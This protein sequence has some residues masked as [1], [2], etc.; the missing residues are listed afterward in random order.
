MSGVGRRSFGVMLP[1]FILYILLTFGLYGNSLA[2]WW[3]CDDPQI[4]KHALAHS[5][6]EYFSNPDVWRALIPYSLTP[7]LS[8]TYDLD[9][10]LFG[11]NPFGYFAHNLLVIAFCACLIHTI[12][13]QWV[14]VWH[15][16][17]GALLFL[18]GSPVMVASQ[19]LM[20]RHYVEGLLFY[21]IAL[22]LI[23][24]ELQQQTDRTNWFAGIAFAVAATAKELY[25]PLGFVPLLLPM[26]SFR[27]RLKVVWPLLLVMLLYVPWRWYMLGDI[28]GGYTPAGDLGRNDLIAAAGQFAHIPGLLLA[29]P[30]LGLIITGLAVIFLL[31]RTP[32]NGWMFL[33]LAVLPVLIL[34]PLIP[35]ARMPGIGAG[36]D[37]YFIVLWAAFSIGA[38][39]VFGLV[40]MGHTIWIRLST[41]AVLVT[42]VVCAWFNTRQVRIQI[43]T[44]LQEQQAQ[45]RMLVTA[46]SRDTIYLTPA[47]AAWYVTGIMDLRKEFGQTGHPP[48][49]V[50]DELDLNRISLIDHRVVR[51]DVARQTMSDSTSQ[52]PQILEEWRK[53]VRPAPLAVSMTFSGKVKTLH[54]QLGPYDKGIYT[55]LPSVGRQPV[56]AQGMLRMEKPPE[57]AFRFRY[58]SPEGWIAYTPPLRFVFEGNQNYRIAWYGTYTP[59]ESR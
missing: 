51:Y 20:V 2:G 26:G 8:L 48:Q 25:L 4:L 3:C 5:P 57:D 42:L 30:W 24:R 37:R 36:S 7:W 19:Q 17:G 35:L 11:L 33:F 18:V 50:A 9:H 12:S 58:D 34:M 1:F 39:V 38:A 40:A 44:A 52:M 13:R 15:A 59:L 41:M 10:T 43:L 53:N 21:L 16:G 28:I 14:D 29:V 55:L 49:V 31:L 23:M 56:P 47:V 27:Q 32:Q 45:G 54:W 46:G 6:W 22:W